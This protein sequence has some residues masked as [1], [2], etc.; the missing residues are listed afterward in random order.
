[1]SKQ[2]ISIER[3]KQITQEELQKYIKGNFSEENLRKTI[4]DQLNMSGKNIV[5][6]ELG[7]KLDS[8]SHKWE[9]NDYGTIVNTIKNNSLIKEIG[10]EVMQEIIKQITPEDIL[11]SLNKNNIQSLKKVYRETLM[12]CFTDRIRQLAI[13]HGTQQA[14]TLF[15]EYLNNNETE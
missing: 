2:E 6:K 3:V 4:Q 15:K 5:F 7:L 1:M 10:K 9:L 8:W 12:K 13:E 11:A 14:E